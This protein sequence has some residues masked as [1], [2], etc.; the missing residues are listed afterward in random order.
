MPA[1][2]WRRNSRQLRRAR[3]GAGVDAVAAEDVPDRTR[4]KREPEPLKFAVDAFVAP[5]WILLR[6][7][8][9]ERP[10]LRKHLRPALWSHG[11]A[12][13][14]THELAVP[15]QK[16]RRLNEQRMHT[17]QR[18]TE[19]RQDDPVSRPRLRPRHPT[20]EDV[21]F[22]PQQQDLH[23]LPLLR[24][25]EE[26]Q[27]LQQAAQHP[28]CQA[29]GLKQQRSSTHTRTLRADLSGSPSQQSDT[30]ARGRGPQTSGRPL[31]IPTAQAARRVFGTDRL[32]DG[33]EPG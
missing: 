32:R 8:Q 1:A 26:Q 3:C 17:R 6:Q 18:L 20:A 9:D 19:R 15:A 5:A 24:A 28:I 27:Q 25:S 23:L 2:C 13:V 31:Q 21:Q 10:R 33:P 29:K 22:V 7:A 14:T 30:R 4:R 11:K 16:R 12:P